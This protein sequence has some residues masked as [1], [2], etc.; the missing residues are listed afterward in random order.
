ME[1]EKLAKRIAKDI[2]QLVKDRLDREINATKQ[3]Q[4]YKNIVTYLKQ[5]VEGNIAYSKE[6]L[7]ADSIDNC[8]TIRRTKTE[9]AL[10][11]FESMLEEIKE[12]LS[13]LENE[14]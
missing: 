4:S 6:L 5:K 13:Y 8:F 7:E 10:E 14:E 2:N 9:G 12:S 11:A 3:E 1:T